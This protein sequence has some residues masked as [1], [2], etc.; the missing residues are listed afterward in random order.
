MMNNFLL[1]KISFTK[2]I[3]QDADHQQE[4]KE[5]PVFSLNIVLLSMGP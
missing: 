2:N 3:V 4:K 5:L 1:W